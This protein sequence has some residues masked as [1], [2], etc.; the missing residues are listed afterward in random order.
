MKISFKKIIVSFFVISSFVI[1][2]TYQN[3]GRGLQNIF[4]NSQTRQSTS[5]YSDLYASSNKNQSSANP[6]NSGQENTNTNAKIT[7]GRLYK[8]GEYDGLIAD[9]FYG[10][11]QVRAIIQSGKLTTVQFLSFPDDRSYSVEINTY[12][13]PILEAEA[14][15][16][17]NS[18]VD[19]VSGAT[20][21][22]NAFIKSLDDALSQAKTSF[23]PN[24]FLEASNSSTDIVS[25]ASN[26]TTR[27]IGF[28]A[29]IHGGTI[30]TV[31]GAT[32]V[33]TPTTT[34]T[35]IQNQSGT[36]DTVSGATNVSTPTTT[37]TTIQNQS[38]TVDTV[39]GATNV[40]I[41]TTTDT[42]IQNQSG[43]VDTVSGATTFSSE[44]TSISEDKQLDEPEDDK[45]DEPEDEYEDEPEDEYEDD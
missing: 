35:T 45:E 24:S 30:D 43:T 21:T 11:V 28:L 5:A 19:I 23:D 18:Q 9:A 1:Y 42:T 33:S 29:A 34:D 3:F 38:G 13:M 20:N 31:S 12:A 25:G 40:S 39:S 37:D 4:D 2:A 15:E 17:Q 16:I 32:N 10:N 26:N 22:S 14:I 8:D 36:V 27:S 6:P 7:N 41:P 44:T